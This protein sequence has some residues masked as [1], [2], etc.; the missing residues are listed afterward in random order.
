MKILV[1]SQCFYPETFRINDLCFRLAEQG[2]QVTVL[3]G[4]PNY[5]EGYI[6]PEYRDKKIKREQI[7][8]VDVVRVNICQRRK[9]PVSRVLNYFSFALTAAWKTLFLDRDYD[10]VFVFQVSPVTQ[11]F[12]AWVYKLKNKAPVVANCQDLWPDSIKVFGFKEPSLIFSMVRAMSRWLYRRCDLI[13]NS[14]PGFEA[15]LQRVCGIPTQKQRY[16]PN[17]AE[18]FYLE[19]GN[20]RHEDGKRHLL[21]A[22]NIGKAQSLNTVVE[23]VAALDPAIREKLTVDF[24]GDGSYLEDLQQL[25]RDQALESHFVFHGRKPLDQLREYYEMADGF[26]LTLA[27]DS[28]VSLTIPSKLQSYM[29]AG[30]PVLAAIN[31]GAREVIE[32][33]QCGACVAAGD[34]EA[35]AAILKEFVLHP[36]EYRTMG[37]AGRA[38]FEQHFTIQK[39]IAGLL[40]MME[41][42]V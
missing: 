20:R 36:E 35:F 32:A 30:K 23:A 19:F 16:L 28:P 8:G 6:Y 15:Y 29:G 39:Y 12:P 18:D 22:G 7:R 4:Y 1:I 42:T 34:A 21:F 17:F 10:R 26:L 41:E 40:A 31:G 13:I 27:G 11:I 14:S 3:T 33:A 38:Y 5:P 24:L 37:E 9:N 2:H 25:I